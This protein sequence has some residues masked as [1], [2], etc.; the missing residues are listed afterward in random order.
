MRRYQ[1]LKR[2]QLKVSDGCSGDNHDEI[3]NSYEYAR[4][5]DHEETRIL[6]LL[7]S[8]GDTIDCTMEHTSI[9]HLHTARGYYALSY[10]WG[11]GNA[12]KT[13]LIDGQTFMVTPTLLAALK[14][15]WR[16]MEEAGRSV[17]GIWIDAVCIQQAHNEEKSTQVRNMHQ[18]YRSASEVLVWLGEEADGSQRVMLLLQWLNASRSLVRC[19]SL[20]SD[21]R[22]KSRMQQLEKKLEA[23]Y[24]IGMDVLLALE[25]VLTTFN[26]HG[27][28]EY[29][30]IVRPLPTLHDAQRILFAS[31]PADHSIWSECDKLMDR[32][33]F[34]RVWTY[35]EIELARKGTV[36]CGEEY[37]DWQAIKS[38]RTQCFVRDR[39]PGVLPW[40]FAIL[41]PLHWS[42]SHPGGGPPG[43][44]LF[45][46]LLLQMGARQA[47][48]RRDY[49]YGFMALLD[50]R[51][52]S[53]ISVDYTLSTPIVYTSA[54]RLACSL[55]DGVDFWCHLIEV[56]ATSTG[57]DSTNDLPSW[58]PDLSRMAQHI[59]EWPSPPPEPLS[60]EVRRA[61]NPMKSLAF[62][63]CDKIRVAGVV[64]DE[65]EE[66]ATLAA[67]A[68]TTKDHTSSKNMACSYFNDHYEQWRHEMAVLFPRR[69]VLQQRWEQGYF[70]AD[71]HVASSDQKRKCAEYRLGCR[72]VRSKHVKS[73][74]AE[75]G[76]ANANASEDVY[77]SMLSN[78]VGYSMNNGRFFFRSK[79]GRIGYS[80]QPTRPGDQICFVGGGNYL[81]VLSAGLSSWVTYASLEG[82]G[83]QKILQMIRTQAWRNFE[84]V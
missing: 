71:L 7:N 82:L 31:F 80:P 1:E 32:D 38:W 37:A 45:R 61:A 23:L 30:D 43:M 70:Y 83:N 66:S 17:N 36:L 74:L 21:R 10:C 5:K 59:S 54:V 64:L 50:R 58:C 81:H 13:I 16:Y 62:V 75:S 49:V 63:S 60:D 77:D 69:D 48:D 9:G 24:D 67:Y 53:A 44:E 65:V 14:A 6:R 46:T 15:V 57:S 19:R 72:H 55:S 73:M 52:S 34:S 4:L 3:P 22:T 84:L 26:L 40:V 28:F 42:P 78:V 35:Q 51:L 8:S 25:A 76:A 47:F 68:S 29:K 11:S 20:A 41:G 33:W 39:A 27:Q 18:I 2:A 56:S 79:A 12:D